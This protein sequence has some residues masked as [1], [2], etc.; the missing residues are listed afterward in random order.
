MSFSLTDVA[1]SKIK[2]P[3]VYLSYTYID[4]DLVETAAFASQYNLSNLKHQLIARVT[5]KITNDL[6]HSVAFR[7]LQRGTLPSYS[8][9][10]Y[11]ISYN[12]DKLN[13]Y[14]VLN[15]ALD[16]IYSESGYATMP[17]RVIGGGVVVRF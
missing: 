10:D 1:M 12:V 14:L 8:I 2:L 9:L 3:E 17:G 6:T 5:N 11:K 13:F 7:W 16:S 15:N 4:A